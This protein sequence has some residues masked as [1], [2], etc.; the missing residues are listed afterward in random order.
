MRSFGFVQVL[1]ILILLLA[2]QCSKAQDYAV[3]TRGDTLKGNVK[4]YNHGPEKKVVVTSDQ[5]KKT[6]IRLIEA[7]AVHY[8]GDIYKPL[9]GPNGYTFMKL[10]H[11]G[12]LS[13]Y[14]YQP[15]NQNVY[16]GLFLAKLDGSSVDVPN[17]SFKKVMKQ[18]LKDCPEVA[19]KVSDGEYS[20][21]NLESLIDEYNQ[22][23]DKQSEIHE[24]K[25]P[26]A[27]IENTEVKGTPAWDILEEK[28][29]AYPDFPTKSDAL[30]MITEIRTKINRSEKVP[31]FLI[32]GL[33]NSL[34]ETTLS[35]ELEEALQNIK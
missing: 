19:E 4:L 3:T 12:F 21:K 24:V 30:D 32:D 28:V 17:L 23:M 7:K 1:L 6:S 31:N 27:K 15:P 20:R 9:K 29:N 14:A 13:L 18:F 33:K 22:C 2:Y 26:V 8:E 11:G 10:L 16:D 5:K 25:K 34:R 35:A